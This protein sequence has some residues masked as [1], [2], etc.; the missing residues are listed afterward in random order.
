MSQKRQ[1]SAIMFTDIVGYTAL[2]Q[3]DEKHAMLIRAKHRKVFNSLTKKYHGELIQYYGDG[4]LSTFK[5]S[6]EAVKCAIDMQKAFQED[7]VISVRIGVHIGDIIRT[8]S[9]IIGDAVNIA[10]RIESLGIAGGILI[11]DKVNDQLKNQKDLKTKFLDVF[12]L[13]NVEE[14]LSIYSVVSEGIAIPKLTAMEGKIKEKSNQ[15]L[16]FLNLKNA[17]Q[18][19]KRRNVFKAVISFIVFSWVLIQAASILFPTFGFNED[20]M[21]ILIMVLCICFPIWIVF[22]YIFE[23]TTSGFKKTVSVSQ[24]TP[25]AKPTGK[26]INGAIIAGLSMAVILLVIDRVFNFTASETKTFDTSIAVLAF[27]DMSPDKDQE[28]F[29]DGITEEILNLLSKIPDLKVIGRTSSFSFKNKDATIDEIGKAL[30]VSHLL[31]GSIRK[32]G[33]SFRITAQLIK[34]ADGS[35]V[36]SE[37]YEQPIDDIFLIQ[38]DIASAVTQKLKMSLIGNHIASKTVDTEAYTLY[39]K[40]RQLVDQISSESVGNAE[41]LLRQS[42]AIDSLYAPSW[43]LLSSVMY[44]NYFVYTTQGHSVSGGIARAKTAVNRAIALDPEYAPGYSLLAVYNRAEWDFKA[45]N[46]NLQKALQLAPENAMVL[47]AA[48]SHK[49]QFGRLDDAIA[50]LN[51]AISIDPLNSSNHYNLAL[52]NSWSQRYEKASTFMQKYLLMNPKSGLG[53]IGMANIYLAQGNFEEALL[54]ADMD[55]HPFW[56]KFTTMVIYYAQ[57]RHQEADGL[58]QELIDQFGDFASPNFAFVCAFKGDK[59]HAFKWLETSYENKDVVL[60]EILNY[61]EMKSL[62]GD[63]RWNTFI[64]KLNLPKDHGFHR[65]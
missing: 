38:D 22:A 12:A 46:N 39:L 36:W 28:Y 25:V 1:L 26:L 51:K 29:S 45:A 65:D 20:A 32:S 47:K 62:W 33:P 31:Q 37:T 19:L 34:V 14:P 56:N 21:S 35:Q 30:N 59:D 8:D 40:A 3:K 44:K 55:Q 24:D 42:I 64:N 18:E 49:M 10:S 4:T 48:A 58:F 17:I 53:H 13:K 23:W 15:T 16:G 41:K 63:P 54:E 2:M 11:S 7:P 27:T 6:V 57:G 52:Y 43:E 9:D 50:L 60:L 61:P 5:S